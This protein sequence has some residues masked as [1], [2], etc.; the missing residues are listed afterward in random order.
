M[1]SAC[2][3]VIMVV[4]KGEKRQMGYRSSLATLSSQISCSGFSERTCLK[5]QGEGAGIVLYTLNHIT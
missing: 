2:I 1:L 5:T 3:K 4:L